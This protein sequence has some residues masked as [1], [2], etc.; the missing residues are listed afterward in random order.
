[1]TNKNNVEV[2]EQMKME[3]AGMPAEASVL[4]E[5]KEAFGVASEPQEGR[6]EEAEKPKGKKKDTGAG[7]YR[8]KALMNV[9]KT[10]SLSG[11]IL[12]TLD[13]G[14]EVR[15]KAV[16]GDWLHLADGTFIFYHEGKWAMRL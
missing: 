8:L 10:P 11:E 13:G 4:P 9:R 12:G 16:E 6:A 1:M 3:G 2:K 7:I 5:E 15:V 14:T